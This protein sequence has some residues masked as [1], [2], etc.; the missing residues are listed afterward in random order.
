MNIYFS[1]NFSA[2]LLD[3]FESCLYHFHRSLIIISHFIEYNFHMKSEII[4]IKLY[5]MLIFPTSR[6]LFICGSYS[7]IELQKFP[8][9]NLK[10]KLTNISYKNME[11][12]S[13]P[14][15][16]IQFPVGDN[17]RML[18][19]C[20]IHICYSRNSTVNWS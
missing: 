3:I 19:L 16:C 15:D 1:C 8:L 6:H 13:S 20:I 2:S 5:F 18:I 7:S 4:I 17:E 11:N 12:L 10:S 14:S 9:K